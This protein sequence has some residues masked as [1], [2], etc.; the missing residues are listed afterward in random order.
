MKTFLEF[1]NEQ[2]G[3]TEK[4]LYV[5]RPLLNARD[6]ASWAKSQG[7]RSTVPPEEMHVTVTYSKKPVDWKKMPRHEPI[8]KSLG[9]NRSVSVLGKEG[10]IVLH[11]EDPALQLHHKAFVDAGCSHDYPDYLTHVT[12]SYAGG[13]NDLMQVYPYSGPLHFGPEVRK[14]IKGSYVP[15]P[16]VK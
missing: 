10:A 15:G 16:E 12:I 3:N 9:G 1:I 4:S 8:V 6:V 13:P 11:F 14:E 5:H 7:F 2:A